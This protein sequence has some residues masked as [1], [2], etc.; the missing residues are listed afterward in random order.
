MQSSRP[1]IVSFNPI[2]AVCAA[3]RTDE[4]V[5]SVR[6]RM[7]Y[8]KAFENARIVPVVVA[9]LADVSAAAAL[10]DRVD[11]VLL[12]GGSDVNPSLYGELPNPML[13]S[14][15]DVRDRWEV[16]LIRAARARAVPLLAIC[17]GAQILN[18]ALGGTLFQD[19]PS[20]HPS[21]IN[22]DPDQPRTSRS[23]SVE[24]QAESRLG[25]A[26]GATRI[27]VN[28]VH[29]QSIRRP[30]DELRIVATAPDGVIE[31]V[32]TAADSPWWCVGVQWHP[33]DLAESRES[34]DRNIFAAFVA[35]MTSPQ[36]VSE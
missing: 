27:E 26:A 7:T 25:R 30:A 5:P 32:E 12:T 36:T 23:H 4:E 31:G 14:V 33:E 29:H 18:V 15:S 10:L 35:A 16:A 9:P 13:G 2:L 28:S 6:L 34:W 19:L 20:Q 3:I 8:L 24:L 1:R 22:H 17:R 11:A 21:D